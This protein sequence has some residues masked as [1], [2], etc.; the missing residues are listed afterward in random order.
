MKLD[1]HGLRFRFWL[2][3]FLFAIGITLFIG[4][5]QTGLIRP[6]YR[7]S[8]IQSV[9]LVTSEIEKDLIKNNITDSNIED[10][11]QQTVNN[12]ACV[13]IFNNDGNVIYS[14]DSIGAGCMF[15]SPYS[16]VIAELF[17]I[18]NIKTIIN[19]EQYEYNENIMNPITNQE[20]IIYGRLV[21]GDLEN[22]YIFVNSA[23]EPIDSVVSF[24]TRQYIA[25]TLIA[26][27]IASLLA[28]YIAKNVSNPI[29][30]MNEEAKKLAKADYSASFDGGNF[31]ETNQLAASLNNANER[32]SKIDELRRD[33]LANVSHDIK[34]PITN[35]KA[36]AEMIR[37]IS[38]DKPDKRE[39]HLDV[40]IKETDYMDRLVKDLTEVSMIESGNLVLNKSNFNLTQKINEIL[41]VLKPLLDESKISLEVNASEDVTIYADEVKIGQVIANYITNAIKFTPL[42]G[43]IIINVKE[44]ED[45]ETIRFEVK[46]FGRGIP[47]SEQS[48][49]WDRYHKS[50]STFSRNQSST[51]LGLSIVK[52]IAD[53]HGAEIGV[54]SELNKGSTFYFELKENHEA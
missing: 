1:R 16:Q 7:N 14:A 8:K 45:R 39:K 9:K 36:Y 22:Y 21:R 2:I 4:A 46:D 42:N 25:Y 26:I 24:F 50:S 18:D 38:G 35:I 53:A 52:G 37:D 31:T 51:G 5:L 20:M 23:L 54:D 49:I 34:T 19:Q 12:N 15:N 27:V 43:K 10:A 47:K 44:D 32:L 6:Y 17:D 11:L 40:I 30:T 28:L 13:V 48:T 33:L 41:D 3:F 29:I